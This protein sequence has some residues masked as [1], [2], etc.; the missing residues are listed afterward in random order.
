MESDSR[1]HEVEPK[2]DPRFGQEF[3]RSRFFSQTEHVSRVKNALQHDHRFS[4]PKE[5]SESISARNI[6]APRAAGCIGSSWSLCRGLAPRLVLPLSFLEGSQT[7]QRNLVHQAL[8][9]RFLSP[10]HSRVHFPK[11]RAAAELG[12]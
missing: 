6:L 2:L 5:P 1:V 11:L 7:K 12:R 9:G 8:L 3:T 10:H 4:L